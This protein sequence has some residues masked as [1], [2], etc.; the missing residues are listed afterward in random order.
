M[1]DWWLTSSGIFF[2]VGSVVMG[3]MVF[4]SAAL[5]WLLLDLRRSI[6]SI[7][8]RVVD[9][10]DRVQG[11][12]TNVS[13]VTNEVGIRTRGIVRVVDDHAHTA[14]EIVEKF[15]PLILGITIVTKIV[16]LVRVSRS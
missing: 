16:K 14:L 5:I 15:A 7:N 6:S 2:V 10:T 3:V 8:K 1:P 12:A 13:D 4:V 9:L 11:I